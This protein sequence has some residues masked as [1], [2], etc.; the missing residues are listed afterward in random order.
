MNKHLLKTVKIS[1]KSGQ[2]L[3]QNLNFLIYSYRYHDTLPVADTK[4]IFNMICY[5]IE[6]TQT[7]SPRYILLLD[8]LCK[9]SSFRKLSL[10]AI[11]KL[12]SYF[13]KYEGDCTWNMILN[14]SVFLRF[15]YNKDQ[16]CLD[17][18]SKMLS[19][20]I[21]KIKFSGGDLKAKHYLSILKT[22]FLKEDIKIEEVQALLE[23]YSSLEDNMTAKQKCD[24]IYLFRTNF[25]DEK[26]LGLY[27]A[28]MKDHQ[29]TKEIQGILKDLPV[30]QILGLWD[31]ILQMKFSDDDLLKYMQLELIERRNFLEENHLIRLARL[32]GNSKENDGERIAFGEVLKKTMLEKAHLKV[33]DIN[34]FKGQISFLLRLKQMDLIS[35]E[36]IEEFYFK[37]FFL[38]LDPQIFRCTIANVVNLSFQNYEK[39]NKYLMWNI[40][41]ILTKFDSIPPNKLYEMIDSL[42]MFTKIN[43]DVLMSMD[44]YVTNKIKLLN[45]SKAQ[46][47]EINSKAK[48]K[49]FEMIKKNTLENFS[50][51]M[52]QL[53]LNKII[54]KG[55]FSA[56]DFNNCFF[57]FLN[58]IHENRFHELLFEFPLNKEHISRLNDKNKALLE[59][60]VEKRFHLFYTNEKYKLIALLYGISEKL[61]NLFDNE[62]ISQKDDLS[63]E[64]LC[65]F[66]WIFQHKSTLFPLNE[67][68]KKLIHR[69]L[70]IEEIDLLLKNI[71]L[72]PFPKE[73]LQKIQVELLNFTNIRNVEDVNFYSILVVIQVFKNK[74]MFESTFLEKLKEKVL[75]GE[76]G[77]TEYSMNELFKIWS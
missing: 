36:E 62:L 60:L 5:R 26:I 45:K 71:T 47:S 1:I 66:F 75:K 3:F 2:N 59:K 51:K 41:Q 70:K 20:T 11:Y 19:Q 42:R 54:K 12:K 29:I 17:H 64:Q 56:F 31:K 68:Q 6:Q 21:L 72:L 18:Y 55:D 25:V 40:S 44:L 52:V 8:H 4:Q 7:T 53:L 35:G 34:R 76:F 61:N 49:D 38:N 46:D 43:Y 65:E 67:I 15:Y 39:M 28:F 50:L 9:F 77:T 74:E 27:S 22:Y 33:M 16:E 69:N 32:I 37:S 30:W 48:D 23:I 63:S 13:L 58:S 14:F 10:L 24:L 73:I 57:S